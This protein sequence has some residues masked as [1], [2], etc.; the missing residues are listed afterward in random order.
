MFLYRTR[1]LIALLFFIY[2]PFLAG[3]QRV[4]TLEE[5]IATTL[6][7]NYDIRIARNDSLVAAIDYSYR[8]AAFLPSVN[9][10]ATRT[11]NNNNQKQTLADGSERR[12]NAIHSNNLQGSIGL[13]WVLFD[14]LKMFATRDKAAAL[15]AAGSFS[16]R[17]QVVN[18][19]AQVISTYYNIARQQ[20][21]VRATDVQIQ[22]NAER[23]KLAQ[24]KLDIGSGAKPDVLQSKVDL[25]EQRSMKVQQQ[26]LITQLKQQLIQVMNSTVREHEFIIPD[27]IPLTTRIT[28]GEIQE[29]LE[30]TNPSLLLARSNIEVAKYSLKETKADMWPVLSFGSAYN[31]N[32]TVNKK[33]LNTFST[34]F[35]QVHGYN[36]GLTAT[37]PLFNQ[38]RVRRQIKQDELNINLQQVHFDNQKSLITLAVI[39]AFKDYQ[40]QQELLELEKE[41]IV[42]A[43]ENVDIVFQTYK[44]GAATLVQLREAQ[45]SLAQAYDRLIAARYNLKLAET[46]LLR[47]KGDIVR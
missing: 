1:L 45:L 37:I 44:L 18:T 7:N 42:L 22:L 13:D 15:L 31:Y 23:A 46:E 3:A 14:G 34:L 19:V 39:N 4:L 17:E 43:H 33:V 47:L 28:L 29:Q 5:A 38:F 12:S 10:V 32:R 6:Q 24:Y 27:T 9:A 11:F 20:Q 21:L 8:N 36:Y 35:N 25:N 41:N 16:A 30:K 26:T 40:Q 2:L